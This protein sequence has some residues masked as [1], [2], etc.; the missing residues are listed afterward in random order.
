MGVRG[1]LGAGFDCVPKMLGRKEV[2]FFF[3]VLGETIRLP[4]GGRKFLGRAARLRLRNG[5]SEFTNLEVLVPI[6]C[7]VEG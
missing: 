5:L 7:R 6:D 2:V 4:V 1:F 3:G